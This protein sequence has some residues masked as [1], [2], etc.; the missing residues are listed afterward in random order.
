M[1]QSADAAV[2]DAAVAAVAPTT[3]RA[4]TTAVQTRTSK[5]VSNK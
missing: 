4:P 3:L 2:A 1:P 5:R